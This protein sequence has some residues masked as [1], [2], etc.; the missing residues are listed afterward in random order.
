MKFSNKNNGDMYM[1]IQ[2]QCY[3]DDSDKI[4]KK[5]KA[6]KERLYKLMLSLF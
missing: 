3:Y 1:I 4:P 6:I 2:K 5:N